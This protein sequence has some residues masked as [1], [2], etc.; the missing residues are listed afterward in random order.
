VDLQ[1]NLQDVETSAASIAVE[2]IQEL[3]PIESAASI[4]VEPIQELDPIES[5]ASIAVG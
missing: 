4:A 5:A 1:I 2:P 3:A